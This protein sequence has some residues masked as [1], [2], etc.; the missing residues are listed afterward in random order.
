M[1]LPNRT[2]SRTSP[3]TIRGKGI[4]KAT[5]NGLALL[6]VLPI[7]SSYRVGCLFLGAER[8]FS[9]WAQVFALFPGLTGI[10][11]RRA[12]FRLV[13]P[14]CELDCCVC[15]GT[16]FS[17]PTAEIGRNVYVGTHCCLG[18]ITLDDDV[19]L[20]SN[21]SIINGGAQHGIDRLDL[22]IRDQPGTFP[23]VTVG[24]DSWIGDRS[25]VLADVGKHC[26]VG[27]GS[28]VTKPIP[29][30]AIAVGNPARVI[31]FRIQDDQANRNSTAE[32][33][34]RPAAATRNGVG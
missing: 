32:P 21:V 7:F 2:V 23:R 34:I 31:R 22:P 8:T 1:R 29:D 13:L 33:I 25:I 5:A 11:L 20:G 18:D 10:Y 12:F 14:R 15:F 27:A 26:V 17:H 30:Y 4:L 3:S 24:R 28:V 6:L 9:G 19:L 16:L